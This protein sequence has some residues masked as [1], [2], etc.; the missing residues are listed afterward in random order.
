VD[1][2]ELTEDQFEMWD[3][4]VDTSPHGT[5][6]HKSYWLTACSEI[7]RKKPR[8][9]GCF[10]DDQLV[11]GCSLYTFKSSFFKRAESTAVMTPYGGLL[12]IPTES[13]SVRKQEEYDARVIECLI[14]ELAREHFD[15]VRIINPP[16]FVDIRP[17][18]WNGWT[19]TVY[20]SY[21]L[22]LTRDIEA[23]VSKNAR[24]YVR[25]AAKDNIHIRRL[26]IA[27]VPTY[28]RLFSMTFERQ[29]RQPPVTEDFLEKTV[30]VLESKQKGEMWVA[31]TPE[32][33]V[34]SAEIVV[35]DTKRAYRWSAASHTDLQDM[36]ATSLLLCEMFKNLSERGFK[37]IDL[38]AANT[39]Q[40]ARFIA[41]FN[42]TLR[43]FYGLE[44]RRALF[45]IGESIYRSMKRR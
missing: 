44:K 31:E 34:A 10:E 42:P 21:Y 4:L 45:R 5:V 26:D 8:F 16:S 38:M 43:P 2:R 40:L 28:Y 20:H 7:L 35:Y 6:F 18:T 19:S 37:E 24:R 30:R 29:S 9:Y 14:E 3:E 25:K 41:N 13:C 1:T 12:L 32:G 23:M 11:G 39:P 33:D 36:G 15:F 27:D 22:H 17:L